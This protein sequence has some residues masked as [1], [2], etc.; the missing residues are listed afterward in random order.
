MQQK[1]AAITDR[2]PAPNT[3]LQIES[4]CRRSCG[5]AVRCPAY[6]GTAIIAHPPVKF[7]RDKTGLN[8]AAMAS[9][10]GVST[11]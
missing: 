2:R 11:T 7:K 8:G 4:T 10:C 6:A 1:A 3:H 9:G 5:K